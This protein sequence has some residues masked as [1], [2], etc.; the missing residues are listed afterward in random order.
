MYKV[1]K[2]FI[3]RARLYPIGLEL[4]EGEYERMMRD[5]VAIK[6]GVPEMVA[7]NDEPEPI[8]PDEPEEQVVPEE[9]VEK[10]V[11]KTQK[12]AKSKEPAVEAKPPT[13]KPRKTKPMDE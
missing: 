11:R 12:S 10:P 13:R 8:V 5:K 6:R 7:P 3:Y 1:V 9:V 4:T 2:P